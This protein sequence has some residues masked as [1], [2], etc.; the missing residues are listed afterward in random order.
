MSLL[1]CLKFYS[2]TV[3]GVQEFVCHWDHIKEVTSPVI[4][5]VSISVVTHFVL[6]SHGDQ[7]G[8]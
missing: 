7:S 3:I 6:R 4:K 2:K 5:G 1:R 8:H